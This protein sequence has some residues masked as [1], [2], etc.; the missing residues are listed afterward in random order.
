MDIYG[1]AKTSKG[2][3]TLPGVLTSFYMR[4]F[5]FKEWSFKVAVRANPKFLSASIHDLHFLVV[6][7][8]LAL[9]ASKDAFGKSHKPLLAAKAFKFFLNPR[10]CSGKPV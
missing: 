6:A 2:D 1:N 5:L 7:G 9:V 3:M 4:S 8:F 10:Y